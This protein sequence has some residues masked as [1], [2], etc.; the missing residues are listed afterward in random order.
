MDGGRGGRG[1]A[2]REKMA[3]DGGSVR[4]K[5]E[6]RGK[7]GLTINRN[8]PVRS[9]TPIDHGGGSGGATGRVRQ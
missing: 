9:P 3:V 5:S 6:G 4:E 1:G 2:R 7:R 8:P